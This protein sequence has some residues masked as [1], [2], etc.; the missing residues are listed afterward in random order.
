MYVVTRLFFFACAC[1]RF[2][3]MDFV[4]GDEERSSA[5]VSKT[6]CEPFGRGNRHE[7]V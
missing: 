2:D 5:F 1:V 4:W 7:T 6:E 3:F